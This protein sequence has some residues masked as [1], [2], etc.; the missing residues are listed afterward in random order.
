MKLQLSIQRNY[1]ICCFQV[2]SKE[3]YLEPS[4]TSK[5]K[6]FVKIIKQLNAVNYFDKRLD[7][8]C[9]TRF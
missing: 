1:K 7:L 8:K 2:F 5:I 3:V 9:L 4:Q 6:P